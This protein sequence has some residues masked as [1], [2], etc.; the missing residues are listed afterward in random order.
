MKLETSEYFGN[1]IPFLYRRS[2][3]GAD[4]QG[5][6][7]CMIVFLEGEDMPDAQSVFQDWRLR[8]AVA[9]RLKKRREV[10]SP[11]ALITVHW[12]WRLLYSYTGLR[13]GVCE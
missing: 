11:L 6:L 3:V 4:R 7:K 9:N 13:D 1:A 12:R 10:M 8:R 2:A 5:E